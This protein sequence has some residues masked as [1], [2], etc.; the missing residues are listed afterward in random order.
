MYGFNVSVPSEVK[1]AAEQRNVPI[2]NY[3][4]IYR[5]IEDLRKELTARLPPV[6]EEELQGSSVKSKNHNIKI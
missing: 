5:L 1:A 3:N 6:E 4:V 2:R